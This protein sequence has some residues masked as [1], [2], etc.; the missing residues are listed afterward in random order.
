VHIL[1]QYI[2]YN[3]IHKYKAKL[4]NIGSG[5]HVLSTNAYVLQSI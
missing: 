5:T 2:I 3:F 1:L 4:Y